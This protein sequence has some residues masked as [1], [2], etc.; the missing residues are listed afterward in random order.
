MIWKVMLPSAIRWQARNFLTIQGQVE[1]CPYE[2]LTLWLP[3]LCGIRTATTRSFTK[4]IHLTVLNAVILQPVP[5]IGGGFSICSRLLAIM[6]ARQWFLILAR[7]HAAQAIR[8]QI[9]KRTSARNLWI[10]T[11]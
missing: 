10:M 3:I 7:F 4:G 5:P 8:D 9:V 2:N 1:T 6:A 11:G